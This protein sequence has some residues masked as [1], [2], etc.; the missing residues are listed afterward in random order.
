M[1]RGQK[2]AETQGYQWVASVLGEAG[3]G[4]WRSAVSLALLLIRCFR[5]FAGGT[6]ASDSRASGH[7]LNNGRPKGLSTNELGKDSQGRGSH[8]GALSENGTTERAARGAARAG[9]LRC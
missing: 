6:S 7:V 2:A 4:L 5:E 8:L 9:W 3:A 1:K